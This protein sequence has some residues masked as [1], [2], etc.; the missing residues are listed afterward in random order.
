MRAAG[1][2]GAARV[3]GEAGV[4]GVARVMGDR[5]DGAWRVRIRSRGVF[6][7][8]SRSIGGG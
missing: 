2:A 8:V 3:G 7:M 6:L 1:S 4:S 5:T